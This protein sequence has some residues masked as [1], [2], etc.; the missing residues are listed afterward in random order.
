MSG[1]CATSRAELALYVLGALEEE[2]ERALC[3]AHLETCGS[4]R[5]AAAQLRRTAE[6]LALAAPPVDPPPDLLERVLRR[7]REDGA[8]GHALQQETTRAWIPAGEGVEIS[9]LWLDR[10]RERHSLLIRMR[11]GA[12]LPAHRHGGPEECFVVRGD[13]EDGSVR[14]REGDYVRF[15]AGTEHAVTT[16][17][18]CTLLVTASLR[19]SAVAP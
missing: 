19:D 12:R 7:I 13:I 8:P 5:D 15:E 18:G 2:E 16:R 17:G 1:G 11:A 4:C 6:D 9:P 14:L 3:D 10:E